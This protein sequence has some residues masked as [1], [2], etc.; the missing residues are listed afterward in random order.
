MVCLC[1]WLELQLVGTDWSV[2]AHLGQKAPVPSE[3]RLPRLRI[4][5]RLARPNRPAPNPGLFRGPVQARPEKE[6]RTPAAKLLLQQPQWAHVE[7]FIKIPWVYPIYRVT[8]DDDGA[9]LQALSK[10]SD[11]CLLTVT[12]N[13]TTRQPPQKNN[14]SDDMDSFSTDS[15]TRPNLGAGVHSETLLLLCSSQ[16]WTE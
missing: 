13:R 15:P 3:A 11:K 1:A 10:H 6:R 8:V 14:L 12:G 9:W 5:T 7:A 16:E 2:F 4:L